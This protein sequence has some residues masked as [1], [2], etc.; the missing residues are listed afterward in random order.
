VKLREEMVHFFPELEDVEVS[1]AWTGSC[2][3]TGDMFPHVGQHD[4]IYFATGYCFSGL[5]MAPYLGHKAAMR[6]LGNVEAAETL[7]TQDELRYV[8]WP[9]RQSFL[10]P[11]AMQYYRMREPLPKL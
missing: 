9:K 2:A 10:I 4:G 1:H 11:V 7:F 5:A 3:A 8:P 6:L